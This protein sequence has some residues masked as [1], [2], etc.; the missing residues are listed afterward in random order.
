LVVAIVSGAIASYALVK[1]KVVGAVTGVAIA[2]S[3]M[4]PLVATGIGLAPGGAT[5]ADAFVL[6]L[7]NV[8]GIL[9]ASVAVFSWLGLGRAYRAMNLS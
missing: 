3:L 7:L 1:P 8:A 5:A 2:V 6:F 4:P 9:V